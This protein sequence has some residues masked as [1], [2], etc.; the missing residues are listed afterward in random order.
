M[1]MSNCQ[2]VYKLQIITDY[3][4]IILFSSRSEP[5]VINDILLHF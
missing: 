5:F 4:H 1:L 3:L 2:K